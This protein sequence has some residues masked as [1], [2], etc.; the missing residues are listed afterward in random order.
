M[1]KNPAGSSWMRPL[2]KIQTPTG[3]FP[4]PWDR[5]PRGKNVPPGITSG[6]EKPLFIGHKKPKGIFVCSF[7]LSPKS[8]RERDAQGT[9]GDG[10]LW[11]KRREWLFIWDLTLEEAA[12]V[13]KLFPNR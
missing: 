8:G 5:H 3:I 6:L 13:E 12:E 11:E 10:N 2:P 7:Q 1:W 9:G 4:L